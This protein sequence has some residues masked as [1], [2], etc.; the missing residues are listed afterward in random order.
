MSV[1]PLEAAERRTLFVLGLPT[2]ALA[3]AITVVT[4]YA[5]V[6]AKDFISSTTVIGGLIAIEGL[7]A[8]WLPLVVG[9][10]SDRLQTPIG[11]RL[12]FLAAA[13]PIAAASL[14]VMGLADSLGVMAVMVTL[15]FVAYFIAYEPYRALYPDL[16]PNDIAARA[17]SAQAVWRGA[18]TGL[19]LV[20]GG[21]LL[22]VGDAIPFVAGSVVFSLAMAAFLRVAA[23]RAPRAGL[24]APGRRRGVGDGAGRRRGR[25][26]ARGPGA[27]LLS[28]RQRALGGLAE[29]AEDVR[30]PLH[31][32]RPGQD[33][34][35]GRRASS[36]ASRCWSC[37]PPSSAGGS[38][39]RT[40]A[41][42]S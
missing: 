36:A 37:P 17:Q 5:P 9:S 26:A 33:R 28:R 16:I 2:A 22:S 6:V 41:C 27:A 32:H 8:L 1:R 25:A 18:G 13:T 19:A 15:F 34:G 11:G 38:P 21:L 3:L 24:P 29:R 42:G 10:W 12:P 35:H 23:P 39:T 40:G 30:V 14:A 7:L 20:G 31:R 4:T